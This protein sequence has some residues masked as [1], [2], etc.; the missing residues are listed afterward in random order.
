SPPPWPT[1][2]RTP[3]EWSTKWLRKLRAQDLTALKN[4]TYNEPFFGGHFPSQPI[5]PGVLIIEAMAQAGAILFFKSHGLE[6][7][8][9]K[10]VYL[11]SIDQAKFRKLVVP[12]DQL[13]I[14]VKAIQ[15]RKGVFRQEAVAMVDGKIAAEAFIVAI[16]RDNA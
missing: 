2:S 8:D 5:M 7:I 9:D 16:V 12:G 13:Q 11:A 10:Q 15:K 3:G 1:T 4:V 14:K 6:H